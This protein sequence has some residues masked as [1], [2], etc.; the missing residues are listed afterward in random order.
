MLL[1]GATDTSAESGAAEAAVMKSA[2]APT[3]TEIARLFMAF[4]QRWF[5]HEANKLT[6]QWFHNPPVNAPECGVPY[7]TEYVGF[8]AQ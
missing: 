1:S 6:H 4:L 2:L 7:F 5:C 8:A 3:A